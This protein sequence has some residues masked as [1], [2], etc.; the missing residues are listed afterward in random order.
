MYFAHL[1]P[2]YFAARAIISQGQWT[3]V[4][5]T[6]LWSGAMISTFAP[7]LDVIYN[8]A[9]HGVAQHLFLWTHSLVL[10]GSLAL[11]WL[12]LWVSG[13]PRFMTT[14]IGLSAIGGLSHLLLDMIVHNTPVLYPFSQTMYGLAPDMVAQGG[15][16]EYVTHPI[17]WLE[18][19]L[20]GVMLIAM[21]LH[22]TRKNDQF[23][24]F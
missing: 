12:C 11:I 17:F 4:Q 7:D 20:L 6:L 5:R 22:F 14:L 2:G 1:T 18:P 16:Y 13:F 19:L 23:Y 8:A 15:I 9:V 3:P 24:E 10:H 21:S